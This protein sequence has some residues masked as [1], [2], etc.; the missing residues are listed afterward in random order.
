MRATKS[1]IGQ[2]FMLYSDPEKTIDALLASACSGEELL[3]STDEDNVTH[4]LYAITDPQEINT[5]K[6]VMADKSVFVADGHHR[7]ET[8][9]DY[10]EETKNPAA[11]YRMMTFV[12]THNEGL[13]I[14]P[15]HRLVNNVPDFDVS[16]LV[17]AMREHFDVASLPFADVVEKKTKMQMML[18]ALKLD[19][20]NNENALGMYFNDDAFY[21][22]T[23]R[24]LDSMESVAAD[25][26][27]PWRQL[28]VSVLHKL[29]LEKD[30]GI[31][32]AALMAQTNVE[33]IKDIGQASLLAM[34]KVDSGQ[35]QGLFFMNPTSPEMVEAVALQGEKMPQKSTF[36]YPKVFSGLVVN[37]LD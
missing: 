3:S 32:E 5:V 10:Y 34:D 16:A 25:K 15:T 4:R 27:L 8:A 2:I 28:D 36:F 6:E 20:E 37:I 11:A 19:Y 29:V 30:L 1:Q 17:A 21:V 13:V 33:Y 18:D 12:N 26:S 7:Y 22:A 35:A 23:L 31:D 24:S 14:L 9:L